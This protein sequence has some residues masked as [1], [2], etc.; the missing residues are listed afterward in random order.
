M[1]LLVVED[2]TA[3][4]ESIAEGLRLDG[5]EVDT[6]QNG[7]EALELCTTETYDLILPDLN[8]PGLDG[9]DLALCPDRRSPLRSDTAS[10]RKKCHF[11]SGIWRCS[12][13]SQ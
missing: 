7:S 12:A 2:E 10:G 13:D 8:P 11:D 1:H 9:P 3:L 5:Y 4:C 6:C